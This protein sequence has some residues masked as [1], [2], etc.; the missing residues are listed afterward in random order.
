MH[1]ECGIRYVPLRRGVLAAVVIWASG[2][3]QSSNFQLR[4]SLSR[5][6]GASVIADTARTV[7]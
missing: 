6:V 3:L 4:V 7:R 2:I 5:S 1:A